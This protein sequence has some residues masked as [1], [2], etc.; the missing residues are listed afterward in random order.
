MSN[1]YSLPPILVM[2]IEALVDSGHFSSRSDVVKESLRFMI[3]KKNHL[4][5]ASAVE[6][7]KKGK[8]TLTKGAEIAGVSP[9]NFRGIL[10]DQGIV[11]LSSVLPPEFLTLTMNLT[12]SFGSTVFSPSL[13]V[14]VVPYTLLTVKDAVCVLV[15]PPLSLF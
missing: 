10:N 2:Q 8:A 15:L 12:F 13:G 14:K 4:R 3:E 7:Y 5:Y 1:S 9:D 11:T 6:I